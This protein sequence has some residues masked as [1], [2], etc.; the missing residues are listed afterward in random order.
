LVSSW[1]VGAIPGAKK[2]SGVTSVPAR[3]SSRNEP[4]D[5]SATTRSTPISFS[6]VMFAR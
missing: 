2:S 5:A 6:F 3:Q 4:T 1:K